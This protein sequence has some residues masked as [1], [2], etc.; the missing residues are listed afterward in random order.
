MLSF[1]VSHWEKYNTG[2][3]FLPWSYDLSQIGMTVLFFATFLFGQEVWFFRLG[4]L[5]NLPSTRVV[6]I[7]IYG[8][9]DAELIKN[10]RWVMTH[11][12]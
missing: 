5:G 7:V 3:L 6:E 2:I 12:W 10:Q 8:K 9:L 1:I 11:L 4:F